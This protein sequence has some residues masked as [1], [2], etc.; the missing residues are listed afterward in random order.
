MIRPWQAG[1]TFSVAEIERQSFSDPWSEEMLG[2]SLENPAFTGFV[3]E[4]EGEVCGYVGVLT[5]DDAEIA[6][7]AVKREM[8]RKGIGEALLERALE[9][10]FSKGCKNVFLEVRISNLPA[11]SLYQKFGFVPVYVRKRYY[12]DGEDALVMVLSNP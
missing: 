3:Y 9:S 5:A 12:P 10:A 6:L 1:D 7:I 11:K 4:E 8:R 2:A